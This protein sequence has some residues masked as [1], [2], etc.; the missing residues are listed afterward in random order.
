MGGSEAVEARRIALTSHA[1]STD[2]VATGLS[3]DIVRGLTE[4]SA[5]QM[6]ERFGANVLPE[7]RQKSKLLLFLEQFNNPLIFI[8]FG[9]AILTSIVADV[10]EAITI[11]VVVM[12]NA[13][14]GYYQEQRASERLRAV[15]SLT[16]PTARVVRDGEHRV[17][18]ANDLVVGDIVLI[19]SGVRVP[20]DL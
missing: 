19:E 13:A 17:I 14:I 11:F 5:A 18:A 3:I 2:A 15:K 9:A 6:R 16:A 7:A 12:F 10:A 1:E 4:T 8:L 20:A